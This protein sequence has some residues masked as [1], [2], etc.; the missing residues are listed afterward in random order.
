VRN[1]RRLHVPCGDAVGR[2]RF[3][4][5]REDHE[6]V[7]LALP[8][9]ESAAFTADQVTLL[10]R[11][12]GIAFPPCC[13]P[14]TGSGQHGRDGGQ[15]RVQGGLGVGAP[16]T[17]HTAACS[18]SPGQPAGGRAPHQHSEVIDVASRVR[19]PAPPDPVA[20]PVASPTTPAGL[21]THSQVCRHG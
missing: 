9:G 3:V 21:R 19:P 4:S 15:L 6:R 8:P 20:R 11:A 12:L 2:D 18:N 13:C 10:Q 1:P 17:A 14:V 5:V 16:M 7:V